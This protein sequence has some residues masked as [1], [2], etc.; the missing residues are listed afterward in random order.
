MAAKQPS[1]L[2][3]AGG[4]VPAKSPPRLPHTG[5]TNQ[6]NSL[7]YSGKTRP[8]FTKGK[9][10]L[11]FGLLGSFPVPLGSAAHPLTLMAGPDP[12]SGASLRDHSPIPSNASCLLRQPEP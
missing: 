5:A 7:I 2:R 8:T 9:A 1:E 6:G 12:K 3:S 11:D 4:R 10:L